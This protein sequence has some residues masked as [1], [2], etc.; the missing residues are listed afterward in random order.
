MENLTLDLLAKEIVEDVLSVWGINPLDWAR[1]PRAS[2]SGCNIQEFIEKILVYETGPEFIKYEGWG[3]QTF[4][5]TI[6]KI[7]V[8]IF[9]PIHGGNQTWSRTLLAS[10]EV[11]Y[12]PHCS[13]YLRYTE[14]GKDRSSISGTDKVCKDC[15]SRQNALF[16]SENKDTYHRPYISRHRA[17]YNAR[18]AL[19]RAKILNATPKWA[20]LD[21][22]KEIYV[23]CPEGYHVDHIIPLQGEFVSGLHVENNLQYLTIKDNL[24]KSN[25]YGAVEKLVNSSR[26]KR[27][28]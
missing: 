19:R 25:K 3:E 17:E 6:K 26:L 16:Y 20:N 11:R 27:D 18:T 8:P 10:I 22:I 28:A 21:K 24:S 7:L 15:K 9:G 14:Y 23:N 1:P 4:N 13:R 2:F 12:C 5:R